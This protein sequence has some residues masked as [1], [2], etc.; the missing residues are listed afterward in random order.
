[1][2]RDVV[3]EGKPTS[4]GELAEA[5]GSPEENVVAKGK[6]TLDGESAGAN[7]SPEDDGTEGTLSSGN[8]RHGK[9]AFDVSEREEA[10]K[11]KMFS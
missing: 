10:A 8:A 1:M 9:K 6:T 5:N 11:G 3:A 7:V 4:E 2:T